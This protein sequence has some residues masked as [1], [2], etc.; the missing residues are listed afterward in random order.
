V[1]LSMWMESR[2]EGVG[3]TSCTIDNDGRLN[4]TVFNLISSFELHE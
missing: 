1:L 2:S 4:N 3:G